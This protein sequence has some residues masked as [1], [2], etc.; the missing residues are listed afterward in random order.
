[1]WVKVPEKVAVMMVGCWMSNPVLLGSLVLGVFHSVVLYLWEGVCVC[2]A[3]IKH[4]GSLMN[5]WQGG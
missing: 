4:H 1:M 3:C 5:V 2:V